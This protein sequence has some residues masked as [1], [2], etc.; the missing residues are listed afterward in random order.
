MIVIDEYEIIRT[1]ENTL[2]LIVTCPFEREDDSE[3]FLE[4]LY[5]QGF[6]IRKKDGKKI[7]LEVVEAELGLTLL[8]E[9][10]QSLNEE[11]LL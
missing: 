3:S 2:L 1:P 6:W 9:I 5:E 7:H 4:R 10:D 8:I 11:E